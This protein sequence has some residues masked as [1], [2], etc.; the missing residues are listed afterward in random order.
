MQALNKV[1]FTEANV[2]LTL[3][4]PRKKGTKVRTEHRVEQ[5]LLLFAQCSRALTQCCRSSGAAVGQQA[6]GSST[7]LLAQRHPPLLT[8]S[9]PGHQ[10][11][12]KVKGKQKCE[13]HFCIIDVK[14]ERLIRRTERRTSVFFQMFFSKSGLNPSSVHRRKGE[15]GRH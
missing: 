4:E 12:C 14:V 9:E 6:Q 5:L 10:R 3:L 13:E 2:R 11:S 8:Q 15:G 7:A 1:D